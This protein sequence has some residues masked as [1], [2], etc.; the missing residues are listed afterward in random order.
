MANFVSTQCDL[1][2]NF[3][4]TPLPICSMRKTATSCSNVIIDCL[5]PDIDN[6]SLQNGSETVFD[7]SA[8]VKC[9]LGYEGGGTATCLDT[10][11]WDTLPTCAPVGESNKP[12]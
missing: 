1:S 3:H 2:N 10:G 5:E 6:G 11:S 9:N 12:V 8:T 4:K 7:G